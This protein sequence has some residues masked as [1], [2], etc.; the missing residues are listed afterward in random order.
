MLREAL[1]WWG[2]FSSIV[3]TLIVLYEISKFWEKKD[4]E[5]KILKKILGNKLY[6]FL[7]K[8]L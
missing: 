6:N 3:L 7:N 4:P 5:D 2:T 1:I 8:I